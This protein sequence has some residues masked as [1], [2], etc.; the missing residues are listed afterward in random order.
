MR[1]AVV[2]SFRGVSGDRHRYVD[3]IDRHIAVG[4]VER[5]RRKVCVRIREL[6]CRES[7]IRSSRVCLRCRRVAAEREVGFFVQWVDDRHIVAGDGMRF[8]V[9][10]R[11]RGVSRDRHRCIDS[12]DL[13][14]LGTV[15][16]IELILRDLIIHGICTDVGIIRAF[17]KG[18]RP[19]RRTVKNC[20]SVGSRDAYH[21]RF[22]VVIAGESRRSYAGEIRISDARLAAV[23][24]DHAVGVVGDKIIYR[25]SLAHNGVPAGGE[26]TRAG[27]LSH[28]DL[29]AGGQRTVEENGADLSV[30][31]VKK[32]VL[33]CAAVRVAVD[34][35]RFAHT[36]IGVARK[37]HCVLIAVS[38]LVF[39]ERAVFEDQRS[40]ALGVNTGAAVAVDSGIVLDDRAVFQSYRTFIKIQTASVMSGVAADLAVVQNKRAVIYDVDTAA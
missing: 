2:V 33:L 12:D 1:F 30:D 32:Q 29:R 13:D 3:G 31:L 21:V 36:H 34:Q 10:V 5:N 28:A 26:R 9:V 40:A 8:S 17:V 38:D 22:A 6:L 4:H 19:L 16:R 23:C 27:R 14:L 24:N 37:E 18:I 7:H 11:F 25:I 39:G 15:I 35:G 20:R